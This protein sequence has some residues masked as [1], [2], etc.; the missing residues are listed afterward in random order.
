M[1]EKLSYNKFAEHRS[2]SMRLEAERRIG[3]N[4]HS[5]QDD[6]V[7][8]TYSFLPG[9]RFVDQRMFVPGRTES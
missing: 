8:R 7:D 2:R 9:G 3:K 4:E 5:P 6:R 1:Y